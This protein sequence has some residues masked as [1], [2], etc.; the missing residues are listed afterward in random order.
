[1][2]LA[3]SNF[4]KMLDSVGNAKKIHTW[5]LILCI[6][7]REK[8]FILIFMNFITILSSSF[9]FNPLRIKS[10]TITTITILH[11]MYVFFD[12]ETGAYI[13]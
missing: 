12:V 8:T 1:M 3:I 5:K 7:R 9:T 2:F 4:R 11:A 6:L 10:N 13:Y